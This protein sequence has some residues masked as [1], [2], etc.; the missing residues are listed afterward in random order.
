MDYVVL[1]HS[2]KK[3]ILSKDFLKKNREYF[4]INNYIHFGTIQG[5]SLFNKTCVHPLFIQDIK[6]FMDPELVSSIGTGI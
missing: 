5:S 4:K 6:I 1:R 3:Y 2:D